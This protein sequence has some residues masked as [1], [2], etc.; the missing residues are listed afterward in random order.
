MTSHL[1]WHHILLNDIT[2]RFTGTY[3]QTCYIFLQMIKTIWHET[4]PPHLGD[5]RQFDA[6]TLTWPVF[7]DFYI[8]GGLW[9]LL[10]LRSHR[11]RFLDMWTLREEREHRHFVWMIA[12]FGDTHNKGSFDFPLNLNW[13]LS[14][15]ASYPSPSFPL[16]LH[17]SFRDVFPAS[18]CS[19]LLSPV[20]THSLCVRSDTVPPSLANCVLETQSPLGVSCQRQRLFSVWNH[21]RRQSVH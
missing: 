21:L 2:L 1:I 11:C 8:P 14:L 15:A 20:G 12:V 7:C 18:S 3:C 9:S 17:S 16:Y 13:S 19:I 6:E 4:M 5:D 10:G